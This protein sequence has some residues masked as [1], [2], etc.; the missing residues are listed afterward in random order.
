MKP[1]LF[2][3]A[4][5]VLLSAFA[6]DDFER[7]ATA[8]KVSA[9]PKTGKWKIAWQVTPASGFNDSTQRN[10]RNVIAA[11]SS[12]N[13]GTK[14]RLSV[15]TYTGSTTTLA[16]CSVGE[17]TTGSAYDAV[18][19]ITFSGGSNSVVVTGSFTNLV[20]D[21]V[22]YTW[23]AAKRHGL[24]IFTPNR[25]WVYTEDATVLYYDADADETTTLSPSMSSDSGF[26]AI[27]KIEV[28][29]PD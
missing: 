5:C 6:Q 1:I 3:S 16:G 2:I 18:T 20:S 23:D 27:W 29:V 19:R 26:S 4:F 14:I 24:H 8:R 11:D 22:N 9:S 15:R 12:T 21:E 13:S 7:L 10:W 17:M 28:W 25:N